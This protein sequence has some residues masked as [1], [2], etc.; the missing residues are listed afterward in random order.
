MQTAKGV[1]DMH[2]ARKG[3]LSLLAGA[4]LLASAGAFATVE[5]TGNILALSVN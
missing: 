3:S 1:P 4:M 2:H 5:P